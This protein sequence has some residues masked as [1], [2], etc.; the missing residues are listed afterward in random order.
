M[1]T[2]EMIGRSRR[3]ELAV[4]A[5]TAVLM[6]THAKR[7][8]VKSEPELRELVDADPELAGGGIGVSF[9]E[10]GFGTQVTLSAPPESGV[11]TAD[12]ER[13][14]D[15]LAEPQKRPFSAG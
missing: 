14:L 1:A 6:K 7:T 12:L 13:I 15:D 2:P 4:A 11:D 8:L 5:R 10:K 9:S 3:K